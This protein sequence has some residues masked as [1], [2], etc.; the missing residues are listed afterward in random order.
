MVIGLD[1][2]LRRFTGESVCQLVCFS[3]FEEVM[4]ADTLSWSIQ[5][6]RCPWKLRALY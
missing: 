3:V 6:V 2:N 4:A 5:L 1:Q